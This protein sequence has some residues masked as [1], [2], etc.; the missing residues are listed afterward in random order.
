[1]P[2]T[3]TDPMLERARLVALHAEGAYSV[4]ELAARAGV[5]R[6]TA[7]KW[8][9]R[10]REGG[11]EALADRSHA[12]HDQAHRTPPEVE[13]LIVEARHKHPTWGPRK[14]LPYLARRHPEIAQWP[15]AST[16][17][18]ILQRHGL[19]RKRRPRRIPKHPG[20]APLTTSAPNE[21]WTADFKGQFKTRDGEYCYPLTVC[22]A[23]SRFVLACDGLPSVEQY[24]THRQFE[25]LFR[26]YGLPTAIR[27]DNGV[28]FATQAICGLSRLSVWW[29]KLGI[30]HD[31]IAPGQPQQNG[32]HERMHKT[33]KAET[34]RPPERDMPRQQA[35]FDDWRA[36]FNTERPHEALSF[37]TPASVY[38][39]SER[40]MPEA[41]PE[42]EYP[43]HFETR[44]VSRCGTYKWRGRQLFLSQALGHEWI[45]FE[46]VADGV[47]SVWFYDRVLARLDERDYKLRA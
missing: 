10:Y 7:Y 26:T 14:L 46:E 18:A 33:L 31:R 17:G 19:T 38:T 28:P 45:G 20:T 9:A 42:P 44:W 47:W 12:R 22:D 6:K 37:A 21:V 43:G 16:A 3:V 39:P 30:S 27:T 13:V 4:T 25:R 29:L 40:V 35:R 32:A 34:A 2:W 5:S 8:I 23:H 1:M 15:A 11:A 36:E 41:L 24:G